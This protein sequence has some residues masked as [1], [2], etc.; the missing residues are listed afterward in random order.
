M[1]PGILNQWSQLLCLVARQQATINIAIRIPTMVFLCCR[2]IGDL[3]I[4]SKGTFSEDSYSIKEHS[5]NR[6]VARNA[7]LKNHANEAIHSTQ[8]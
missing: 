3:S 1:N 6:I 7:H 4:P 5:D 8:C 2:P